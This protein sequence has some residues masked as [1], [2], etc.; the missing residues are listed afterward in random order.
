LHNPRLGL[1]VVTISRLHAV[2]YIGV[3]QDCTIHISSSYLILFLKN[4]NLHRNMDCSTFD[5]MITD[6]V[7]YTTISLGR[8]LLKGGSVPKNNVT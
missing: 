7:G 4:Q 2:S 6:V 3:H 8:P 5:Q 1:F